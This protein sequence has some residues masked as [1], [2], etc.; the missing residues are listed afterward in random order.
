MSVQKSG[1]TIINTTVTPANATALADHLESATVGL[2]AAGW[3]VSGTSPALTFTS[4]AQGDGLSMKIKTAANGTRLEFKLANSGDTD[5]AATPGAVLETSG[6]TN[7]FRCIMH[8]YGFCVVQESDTTNGWR[9]AWAGL[10]WLPTGEATGV[11]ELGFLFGD[12]QSSTTS[13]L[14]TCFRF[15]PYSGGNGAVSGAI[16]NILSN[17]NILE[18]NNDT[19]TSNEEGSPAMIVPMIGR[20]SFNFSGNPTQECRWRSGAHAASAPSLFWDP[21]AKTNF[22][23]IQGMPFNT[24]ISFDDGLAIGDTPSF[25]GD[26][27]RVVGIGAATINNPPYS[28]WQ[29][30]STP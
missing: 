26:T 15:E 25:G 8:R 23:R 9:F 1:G 19:A 17:A 2:V 14:K 28:F 4:A 16:H 30:L 6:G 24:V 10:L 5:T 18:V 29:Y 11:T 20:G 22:G 13:T 27:F 21:T 7:L 12:A 3:T